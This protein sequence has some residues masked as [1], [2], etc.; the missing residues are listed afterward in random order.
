MKG[1]RALA[2]HLDI[3][4][5][6]VSRALNGRPDVNPETRAR[7]MEAARALGYTPNQSGR[8]LRQGVTNTIGFM[9]EMS[10]DANASSDD[11]FMG[12]FEGVQTVLTRHKLDLVVFP[13][14][15]QENSVDYLA[16]IVRRGL[17]DAMIISA[18]RRRDDRVEYLDKAHIPFIALGR[19]DSG[20]N[21]R[22]VDLDFEGVAK[23]SVERLV[24]QGH[25][26]IALAIPADDIN[27]GHVFHDAYR[28]TLEAQGLAYDPAL[29]FHAQRVLE[30]GYD[31]A[32]AVTSLPDRPTAILLSSEVLS[33]S[34]YRGLQERGIRAGRDLAVI[35]FRNNPRARFL[36]PS[37]TCHSVSLS[38]LGQT[39][40]ETLLA[41]MPAYAALYP[42]RDRNLIWP[43]EL[44]K[45]ESDDFVFA[46]A[47]TTG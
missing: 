42:E 18:T 10:P 20:P 2:R 9:I 36:T 22:W 13:C 34:L 26:R 45:G 27:L 43:M 5:G 1:I 23:S 32:A 11:F 47:G 21:M 8:S 29:V 38:E 31:L 16:R 6:T 39:L 46:D 40:A 35:G 14:P 3:S 24:A 33:L 19:S 25:R 30:G 12:V 7:V 17:V 37:L 4:I 44:V 15:A 41:G 28:A